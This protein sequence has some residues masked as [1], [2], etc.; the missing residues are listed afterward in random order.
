M[1]PDSSQTFTNTHLDQ[2]KEFF[3]SYVNQLV[4]KHGF[5]YDFIVFQ[6]FVDK[7]KIKGFLLSHLKELRDKPLPFNSIKCI[8]TCLSYWQI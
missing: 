7:L 8:Y 2:I 4:S 1:D 5:F 3:A 6:H